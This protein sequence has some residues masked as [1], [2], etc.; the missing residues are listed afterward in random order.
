M[1]RLDIVEPVSEPAKWVNPLM[2]VG[3]SNGKL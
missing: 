1:Q 3:K 2:T